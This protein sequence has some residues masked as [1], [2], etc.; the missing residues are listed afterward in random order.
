[1]TDMSV[2]SRTRDDL[3]KIGAGSGPVLIGPWLSEVGFELLYWLPFL[4]W[5]CAFA[6]LKREDIWVV[7]RGGCRSWYQDIGAHYID[8]LEF[9]TPDE[10]RAANERRIAAQAANHVALGLKA[11]TQSP[12]QHEVS[13]FDRA[14]LDWT[15]EAGLSGQRWIHPSMMYAF[16][17][18]FWRKKAH[19]LY[20]RSTKVRRLQ[21]I[22]CGLS[23][24]ESYVAMKFYWSAAMPESPFATRVIRDIVHAQCESTDVVL[25]HSDTQYDDHP[26]ALVPSHPRVHHV[27]LPPT[28]NL[29]IQTA[30]IAGA[31][32]FVGTYGGF[33]YLAPFLGV[34]TMALFGLDNFRK[35][36]L[37]LM[38]QITAQTLR[39]QFEVGGL[40]HGYNELVK[41]AG[42]R[43]A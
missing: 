39:V 21:P 8:V 7:S 24:P 4:R 6:G 14:I 30:V 32:S 37:R 28:S 5:A 23:L 3:K 2:I 11:G 18:P 41:K 31:T 35:D 29:D 25:L 9:F 33:S 19:D 20:Q 12:K 16:F 42:H 27:D 15:R 22:D 34:P 13:D 17:K 38:K 1:M 10:F 43:A 40:D 36:H 26:S